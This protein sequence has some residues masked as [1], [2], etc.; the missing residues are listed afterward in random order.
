M[1]PHTC[2]LQ[3]RLGRLAQRVHRRSDM[4]QRKLGPKDIFPIAKKAVSDFID[5]NAMSLAAGVA[6]YAALSLAPLLLLM[7]SVTS[8]VG[9]EF[10]NNLVGELS[11]LLGPQVGLTVRE[12][13]ESAEKTPSTGVLGTIISVIT[14]VV[15]ATG[16]FAELQSSMNHIWDVEPK[17]NQGVK[18]V[19]RIRLVSLGVVVSLG[20][21]LLV[22]MIASAGLSTFMNLLGR[23][24]TVVTVLWRVVDVGLS[25]AMFTAMFAVMFR[26]LPD[27]DVKWQN[28]IGG[29]M[30]T[31]GLFVVGKIIIGLYIGHSTTASSYGAAGSLVAMLVW[32]YYSALIVFLGA[33]ITQAWAERRGE[34]IQPSAHARPVAHYEGD[35][36]TVAPLAVHR[37]KVEA[38]VE[39]EAD[40]TLKVGP[41]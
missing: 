6:F 38:K 36:K 16:V 14:L 31:A 9:Q 5:D 22:S 35:G 28:V 30:V 39:A 4:R 41:A 8:L 17:P 2:P 34:A 11:R 13:I 37:A 21:L 3:A 10:Q 25:F 7:L 33:E 26:M 29:A 23:D 1:L 19:L 15:S 24:T 18:S 20:F 40:T 27:V 12:I 32:V